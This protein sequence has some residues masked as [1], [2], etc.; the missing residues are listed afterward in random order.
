MRLNWFLSAKVREATHMWK[1]VHKIVS[2]QRDLLAPDASRKV[3]ESVGQLRAAIAAGRT[4]Q[5]LVTKM[6]ELE[7]VANKWLKPYP[8]AAIRENIEVLLVAIAVAMGIR[9]F[10]A[11]PFKIPTG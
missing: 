4:D 8:N 2:A 10:I 7:T 5:D 9:T 1:H 3:D 6:T 11:Q